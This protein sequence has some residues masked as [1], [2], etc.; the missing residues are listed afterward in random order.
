MVRIFFILLLVTVQLSAQLNS[1]YDE[2]NPILTPDGMELYFTVA[3]HPLNVSGKKDL[4]DIWF[5]QFINGRWS[6]PS[7]VKGVINNAGYNAVLGFSADGRE[8]FLYGHYHSD[9]KAAGSQG[10]AVSTRT[11]QG[12]SLPKN[13]VVPYFQNKSV[14]SG[15]HINLEKTIFIFS[16]DARGSIGNEDIYVSFNKGGQWTEPINIG[17]IVNTQ[18]QELAP[19]L[20]MDSKTL[21]FASNS[22]SSIGSFDIYSSTRLDDT[23]LK[24]TVPINL[25]ASINST[26]RELYYHTFDK[27][28]FF[29][30]TFNS[31]GY[32]DIKYFQI[33]IENNPVAK[34]V[35]PK[36]SSAGLGIIPSGEE[37]MKT[38]IFGKVSGQGTGQGIVAKIIFHKQ[39]ESWA[40]SSSL[41]GKYE[42]FLDPDF[43]YSVQIESLG[44]VSQ[45]EKIDLTKI[46]PSQVE[47]NFKLQ[48]V[49]V[50][51]SINLKSVL[52]KQSSPELLPE[53]NDELDMVVDFLKTNPTVEIELAGHTDNAGNGKL[54]LKLSRDRVSRVK[55]YL[56][57]KGIDGKRISGVGYGGSKPIASNKTDEG[58]RLNRRVE[59]RIL[60]E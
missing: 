40:T 28:L 18:N 4:G 46:S 39:S 48:P 55:N 32:G 2:Q 31:D 7:L 19:W 54:N 36:D 59:F 58:K 41:D 20:S 9:G 56:M 47:I 57:D 27:Q 53:S 38:K 37:R 23:W 60:K 52:F 24:W 43:V 5:S 33:P 11:A 10:I 26:G 35:V 16:A 44:Y 42:F 6:P 21:F 15:G 51:V 1:V 49:S 12:W 13:E 34:A 25:G 14:A 50:G 8:M 30:S 22:P 17:N 45:I 3:H 29:T